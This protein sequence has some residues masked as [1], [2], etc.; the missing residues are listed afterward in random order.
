MEKEMKRLFFDSA[1]SCF[2]KYEN[3]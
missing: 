2:I 3:A 1:F